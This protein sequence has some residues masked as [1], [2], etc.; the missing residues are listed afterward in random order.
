MRKVLFIGCLLAV[1]AVFCGSLA[2]SAEEKK[3]GK[4]EKAA[5]L[6][7]KGEL[8]PHPEEKDVK[9]LLDN[10]ETITVT[11]TDKTKIEASVKS[12]LDN[13]AKEAEF[14]LPK[15]EVTYTIVDG[16][17]VATRITYGSGAVWNFVPP[18]PKEE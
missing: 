14:K 13:M 5:A 17:P 1:M 10:Y 15:G 18:Q 8:I 6:K 11:V 9:V 3:E 12:K 7:A 4:K 2:Q 16:K